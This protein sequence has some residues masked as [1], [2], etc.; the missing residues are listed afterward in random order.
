MGT[1]SV[2]LIFK[3]DFIKK[4][5]IPSDDILVIVIAN[6]QIDKDQKRPDNCRCPQPIQVKRKGPKSSKSQPKRQKTAP[7]PPLR[8]ASPIHVESSPCSLEVQTQQVPSP[9]QPAPQPQEAPADIFEH[10][11]DPADLIISSVIPLE[12]TTTAPPQGKVLTTKLPPMDLL[13]TLFYNY[14]CYFSV[15]IVPSA[16]PADQPIVS[17]ASPRQRRETTLKQVSDPHPLLPTFDYQITHIYPF[18][19]NKTLQ[20][21]YSPLLSTSL[22]TR[23]KKQAP[24]K[25]WGSHRQKSKPSWKT[26]QL[27]Y[28]K[29][30]LN[31]QMILTRSKLCLRPL[32][33][34]SQP[35][36][37]KPCF[38]LHT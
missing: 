22:M 24:L 6:Q 35:M 15:D 20:I 37:K 29:I 26:C 10:T 25:Q 19:R 27:C 30:P 4:I 17:A 14:P 21:A 33:T 31:W 13:F 28:I 16:T 3:Q 8:L 1:S 32:G 12:Q 34:R 5:Y 9:P 23:V 18:F 2:T 38:K 7:S 36:Q 11:A